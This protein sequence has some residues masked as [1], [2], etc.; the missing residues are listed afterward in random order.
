MGKQA[1]CTAFMSWER[2]LCVNLKKCNV[3]IKKKTQKLL[4]EK[5]T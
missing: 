5:P 1:V 2:D 3:L 4:N